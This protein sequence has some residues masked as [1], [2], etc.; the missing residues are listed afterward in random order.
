MNNEL[1]PFGGALRLFAKNE[2]IA[3]NV[4]L[5]ERSTHGLSNDITFDSQN[6]PHFQIKE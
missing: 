4:I 5:L 6:V 1:N 2:A 3:M